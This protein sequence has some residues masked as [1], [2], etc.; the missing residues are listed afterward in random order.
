MNFKLKTLV[1]AAVMLAGS[2]LAGT[3]SAAVPNLTVN[4]TGSTVSSSQSQVVVTVSNANPYSQVSLYY[5]QSSSYYNVITTLGTTD[6]T[7]YLST[8]TLV[9]NNGTTSPIMY[10]VVAGGLQS[11]TVS[12]APQNS[13]SSCY[14]VNGVYTCGGTGGL[15]VSQTS[16]TMN[17][18][19]TLSLNIYSG[20]T[21]SG[22]INGTSAYYLASNTPSGVV[23]AGVSG[24][25]LTLLAT[26]SGTATV[27]VCPTGAYTGS[28]ACAN[29]FVTSS[30][31]GYSGTGTG[32][33]TLSPTS[34]TL[35]GV[36]QSSVVQV[37]TTG[38]YGY[39]TVN[40][41]SNTA[42]VSASIS[43]SSL[44]VLAVGIGNATLSICNQNGYASAS[45][46]ASLY[47][48]VNNVGS[49]SCYYVGS[50]YTCAPPVS[51]CYNNGYSTSCPSQ[52]ALTFSNPNPTLSVG[53]T[54]AIV[55]YGNGIYNSYNYNNYQSYQVTGNSSSG[56]VS[57]VTSGNSLNITGLANGT[58][59]VSVCSLYGYAVGSTGN[60]CGTVYVTVQGGNVTTS[61]CYYVGNVYT[62][63]SQ[64]VV[65]PQ[66]LGASA[67]A[68]GTLIQ[69][70][71]TIYIYYRNTLTA[72]GNYGAF[73]GLGFRTSQVV[74]AGYTSVP[75]SGYVIS[76]QFGPHPWGTWVK[77]GQAIYFVSEYGLIPV[78]DYNTFLNNGGNSANV[79]A[80]NAYDFQLPVQS[81]MTGQDSRLTQ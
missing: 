9:P 78:P 67:Y 1:A 20:N 48:T 2:A 36:G 64:P 45:G 63:P 13:G 33:V 14:Y 76:T 38:G 29:V 16:V 27:Q 46:C 26:G 53:Q 41:N 47:V 28:G 55:I 4:Y 3:V 7:G 30:F 18:G 44:N 5:S 31:N 73:V 77:S 40:N 79:V 24:S 34:L 50:V 12:L 15:S 23:T 22:Y 81:P 35:N 57:A 75:V 66:V 65:Q 32:N 60:S 25:V 6:V 42:V 72:F 56:V 52:S 80:A 74:N 17:I 37:Y 21:N 49:G 19:Q 8:V 69:Q 43:G 10:Y 54:A 59:V 71:S 61:S 51:T 68:N 58:S 39:F 11:N 62:C 70:G